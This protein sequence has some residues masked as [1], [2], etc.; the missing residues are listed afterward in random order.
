MENFVKFQ[1]SFS[2]NKI[3]TYHL[4]FLLNAYGYT[5]CIVDTVKRDVVAVK[6]QSFDQNITHEDSLH[7]LT[8]LIDRDI[9]LDKNF[10]SEDFIYANKRTSIVPLDLFDRSKLREYFTINHKLMPYEELHFNKITEINA[11]VIFA[12][13]SYLTTLMI[14]KFPELRFNHQ[15]SNLIK[16][17]K[18][19][20]T[21]KVDTIIN[22]SKNYMDIVVAKEKQLILHNNFVFK[23]DQDFMYYLLKVYESLKIEGADQTVTVMGDIKRNSAL[24]K[25]I[26]NFVSKVR[27]A[28]VS[29]VSYKFDK[30]PQQYFINM[31]ADL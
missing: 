26:N 9:Y 17:I 12:I 18:T 27:F 13:P 5:Y 1:E 29:N 19:L 2:T 10:K 28:K 30:I 8:D 6:N 15:A 31:L 11:V 3:P 21:N 20:N 22:I 24:H 4:S 7:I 14:N 25:I 16:Q 23:T